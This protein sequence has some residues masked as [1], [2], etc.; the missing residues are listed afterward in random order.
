TQSLI[1]FAAI[2][3]ASLVIILLFTAL[4]AKRSGRP[5]RGT[6]AAGESGLALEARRHAPQLLAVLDGGSAALSLSAPAG[7]RSPSPKK[8]GHNNGRE[9]QQGPRAWCRH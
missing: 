9:R 8:R 1:A 2:H 6:R 5:R 3:I 4:E 7:G